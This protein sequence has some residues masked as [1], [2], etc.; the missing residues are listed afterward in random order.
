[1]L[2][3]MRLSRS[4]SRGGVP[5]GGRTA[6]AGP[7]CDATARRAEEMY[8]EY[9]RAGGGG[10]LATVDYFREVLESTGDDPGAQDGGR[11]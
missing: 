5:G 9:L 6:A 8:G 2:A 1:M 10:V 3:V 11:P 4:A 7:G